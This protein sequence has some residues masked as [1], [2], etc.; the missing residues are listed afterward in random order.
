MTFEYLSGDPAL[1]LV[2]TVDWTASGLAHERLETGE[3][4]VRWARGAGVLWAAA[5]ERLRRAVIRHPREASRA[6][7]EARAARVVLHDLFAAIA[8]GEPH[9]QAL[10]RFDRLLTGALGHQFVA[11]DPARRGAPAFRWQWRGLDQDPG[12]VLRPVVW[13]AAN[14]LVSPEAERIRIC[15]GED[16]GWMYVDRSRNGL[17]RWCQMRTCGTREKSRRRREGLTA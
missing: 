6:L 3:D 5:A 13:S 14:L 12:A 17:R 11:S 7:E 2:N 16:C 9:D 10:E 4:L 15:G 1:D 8:Q